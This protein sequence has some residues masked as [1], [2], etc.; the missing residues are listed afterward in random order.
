M[1]DYRHQRGGVRKSPRRNL[2]LDIKYNNMCED[3]INGMTWA[4]VAEKYDYHAASNARRA[5]TDW[6]ERRED[7]AVKALLYFTNQ[8]YEFL[9]RAWWS[10]ATLQEPETDV[11][12]AMKAANLVNK[13]M[14]NMARINGLANV[15][16]H[17]GD[18]NA[19]QNNNTLIILPDKDRGDL[20]QIIEGATQVPQETDDA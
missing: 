8:R 4:E 5:I 18:V 11:D 3:F 10:R 9:I 2:E 6:L 15:S 7:Q 20:E 19:T 13:L 17:T 12:T 1:P 16:I 14:Y